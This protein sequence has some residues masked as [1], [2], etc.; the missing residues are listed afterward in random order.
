VGQGQYVGRVGNSG[1]STGPHLHFEMLVNG[2]KTNFL[3]M[4]FP[5]SAPLPSEYVDD[6]KKAREALLSRLESV[7]P[8]S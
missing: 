7:K 8:N 2:N 3:S 1:L 5:P 4:K 6:F